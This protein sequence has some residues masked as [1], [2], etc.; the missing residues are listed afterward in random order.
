MKSRIVIDCFDRQVASVFTPELSNTD[1][2]PQ[3]PIR[4]PA[5]LIIPLTVANV[6]IDDF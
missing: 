6:V 5:V 1:N 3:H 2:L 4:C